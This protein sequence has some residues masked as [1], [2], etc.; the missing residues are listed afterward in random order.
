MYVTYIYIHRFCFHTF[1]YIYFYWNVIL[2]YK[3]V[4]LDKWRIYA[5]ACYVWYDRYGTVRGGSSTICQGWRYLRNT[6]QIRY[7]RSDCRIAGRLLENSSLISRRRRWHLINIAWIT[8]HRADCFRARERAIFA[9]SRRALSP[10][11]TSPRRFLCQSHKRC[12]SPHWSRS[13]RILLSWRFDEF[14]AR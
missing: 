9:K 2:V 12:V 11:H 14:L 4:E 8:R 6:F 7:T 3:F 5:Y 13:F 1:S 10:M